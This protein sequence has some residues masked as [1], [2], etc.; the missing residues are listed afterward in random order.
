MSVLSNARSMAAAGKITFYR[1]PERFRK[2][3][4]HVLVALIASGLVTTLPTP[5]IAQAVNLVEVDVKVV[6]KGYRASKLIG[7][8]VVNDKNET[9]GKID[10]LVVDQ[11]SA[12]FAILEVGSFLGIGGH[13][14]AL[15]F[16]SL[17]LEESGDKVT[18]SG[19]TKASLEKLQEFKYE[20]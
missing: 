7:Q 9:V 10:D 20:K 4:L 1:H 13:L 6:A 16:D 15:P 5:I 14:V 18:L 8:N 2:T 19:G 12:L 3:T 17:K 11:K